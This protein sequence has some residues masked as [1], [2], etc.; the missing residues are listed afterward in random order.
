MSLV[1]WDSG[2]EGERCG[3]RGVGWTFGAEDVW[4]GGRV[5]ASEI[6]WRSVGK[7]ERVGAA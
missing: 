4:R 7:L 2:A 1:G 5:V 3:G 6:W